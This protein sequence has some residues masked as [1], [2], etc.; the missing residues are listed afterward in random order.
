M[1][2][3]VCATLVLLALSRAVDVPA[4]AQQQGRY[5]YVGV[6]A[7]DSDRD[8]PSIAVFDINN[9]HRFVRRIRP[10]GAVAQGPSPASP[11]RGA[12]VELVRGIAVH[13]GTRRLYLTTI[14]RILAIDLATDRLVW[15]KSYDGHCCDRPAVSPDGAT[16]YIPAFGRP[17]WYVV[18]AANGE[19]I[20]G[21]EVAGWPRQTIFS[22]DGRYAYLSAWESNVIAV[23]DARAHKVIREIGP[24][25]DFV[26]PFALNRRSTLAFV[27]V[28]RLVGFE[29][30]DLQTGLVL[31]RVIVEGS[32]TREWSRYECASHGIALTPDD[33]KLWIADGVDNRLHVFD[34]S[35]YPP[36]SVRTIQLRSQ[37]RWIT[38][39]LD[40][41]YAYA[42]TEVIETVAGTVIATLEDEHGNPVRTD[43][44][45]EID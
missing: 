43:T 22:P 12:G 13:P 9:G 2:T 26:C 14:E 6:S 7:S 35:V 15:Q 34:A 30:A 41:R 8:A 24:F 23:A 42:G 3:V 27:N 19:P 45:L 17:R 44:V 11:L 4:G 31:D 40:G 33:R 39:S 1:G 36:V 16:I 25:T 5:L 38:F 21:I 18:N 29:V 32:E 28:D 10:L 37:P 20:T